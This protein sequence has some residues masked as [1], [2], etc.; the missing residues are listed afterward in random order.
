MS[1]FSKVIGT[2]YLQQTIVPVISRAIEEILNGEVDKYEV[3]A[4]GCQ[5]IQ[6][7]ISSLLDCIIQSVP[8]LPWPFRRL[9]C[10]LREA[11]HEKFPASKYLVIGGFI[12]L[13]FICPSIITFSNLLPG[14]YFFLFLNHTFSYLPFLI[15]PHLIF[16]PSSF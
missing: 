1:A 10:A 2:D 8:L 12:F 15:L 3:R 9:C 4:T 16:L 13:R 14:D 5:E 11:T 6:T 7:L